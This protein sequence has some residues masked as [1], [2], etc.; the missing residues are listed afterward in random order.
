MCIRD[1]GEPLPELEDDVGPVDPLLDVGP[2]AVAFE[3]PDELLSLIH[4]SEPTRPY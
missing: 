3:E 1:S 2:A 4:I